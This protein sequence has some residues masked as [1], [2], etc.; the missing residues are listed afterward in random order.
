[1]KITFLTIA[2]GGAMFV[3]SSCDLFTTRPTEP[4]LDSGS[5]WIYPIQVSQVFDNMAQ[6]VIELNSDHY[7]RCF[8]TPDDSAA[9]FLFI[10]NPAVAGW[11]IAGDWGYNEEL[12]TVEYLF[13]QMTPEM[14]GFL[15]FQTESELEYGNQDSVW[16][17]KTYTLV[18]PVNDPTLPQEVRGRC[19]FYLAKNSTGY[20]AIYRWEDLENLE[21]YAS[22]TDL[23]A[24]LY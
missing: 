8:F 10:P 21:G 11:P 19:D 24:G 7:I 3:L 22:W 18:L 16:I 5:P 2:V 14:P 17:T 1:M 13:S 20:W 4:P 12:Q 6:A 23:K 15:A 9:L